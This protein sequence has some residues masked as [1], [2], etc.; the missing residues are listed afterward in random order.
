MTD[1]S[2]KPG[3]K[4]SLLIL[5]LVFGAVALAAW[6]RWHLWGQYKEETED[7]Y[8]QGY[9]LPIHPQ[10]AGTVVSVQADDT[11]LVQAGQLIVQLDDA[12]ARL[13][14]DRLAEQYVRLLG[15]VRENCATIERDQAIIKQ[16]QVELDAVRGDWE[17]RK[18]LL[19]SPALAAEARIHSLNAMQEAEAALQ[20]TRQDLHVDQVRAITCHPAKHPS[21]KQVRTDY[22]LA[23]LDFERLTIRAPVNG[24]I[25]RR[26]AVPGQHVTPEDVLMSVVPLHELWVDANLKENQLGNVRVGQPVRL[27]SDLYGPHIVFHG[28]VAGLSAGSGSA[29]SLLPPQNAVGNWIKVVQRLP[30]RIALNP[31]ELQA[32]PLRIGLSMQVNIDTHDRSQPAPSV[33]APVT[34]LQTNI[35]AQ[36]LQVAEEAAQNMVNKAGE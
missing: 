28:V 33:I 19:H 17:R 18:P 8:V 6:V 31:Q 25:A 32:H 24:M 20:K 26:Q 36:Q 2:A 35:Y 22:A 11:Q 12:S 5:L 4:K 1:N 9:D 29:F 3:R 30:V 16:R 10:V 7:A 15:Q 13:N 27:Y 14:L 23:Y 34:S 21:L